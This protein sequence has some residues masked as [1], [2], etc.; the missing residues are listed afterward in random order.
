MEN[1]V[2]VNTSARH[3]HVTQEDLNVLFGEGFELTVKKE[4]MQPGQYLSNQKLGILGGMGKD[5]VTRRSIKG[6]SI[7]GPVRKATQVEVSLTD[8]RT[9]GVTA[10]IRES[11]DVANSGAC[12]LVGPCGEI[13]VKEGVIV[14]K[15]HVHLDPKSAE[16]LGL[17]D[18]DVVKVEVNTPERATVFGDVVIRVSDKFVPE[19]HIDT[20]ESNAANCVGEVYGT[21]IK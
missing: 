16:E 4:L 21:I 8:A 5:G 15:R 13:D 9:L 6:V 20:D 7:L 18:K 12:T 19:M 1:K 2:I 11:G 3:I 14:A 17:K 10:P